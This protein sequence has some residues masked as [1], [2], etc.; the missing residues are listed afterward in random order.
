MMSHDYIDILYIPLISL[1]IYP[2]PPYFLPNNKLI[3]KKFFKKKR[4][5]KR[6]TTET[7]RC[8]LL[9]STL[10]SLL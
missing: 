8:R 10:C 5:E 2:T 4:W 3:F 1:M 7:E 9:C 6:P